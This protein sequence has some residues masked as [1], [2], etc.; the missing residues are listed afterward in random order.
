[1][2]QRCV[3]T[4]LEFRVVKQH[5]G[6]NS[7]NGGFPQQTHG[8][9]P[10]KNDDFVVWNGGYHYFR[11]PPYSCWK[12]LKTY[13]DYILIMIPIKQ[14]EFNGTMESIRD[15]GSFDRGSR[16]NF[17]VLSIW[18]S[19]FPTSWLPVFFLGPSGYLLSPW[20]GVGIRIVAIYQYTDQKVGSG[21]KYIYIYT[22]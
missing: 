14:S 22:Y 3:E 2:F 21:F 11:K 12:S 1:M 19:C 8:F 18:P 9:F 15:P 10:T 20:L 16:W 7:Q 17:V 13:M 5:M 6:G 4:T